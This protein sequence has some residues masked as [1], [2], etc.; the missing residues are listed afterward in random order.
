V[1]FVDANSIYGVGYGLG[2]F[3]GLHAG[4]LDNRFA[5][6]VSVCGPQPFRVD[7]RDNQY[8]GIAR[9][10]QESM[11]LPRL[12]LFDGKETRVPYDI[13]NLIASFAPK[14]VLVICPLL[15]REARAADV[16]KSVEAARA[17]FALLGA[18]EKLEH[19]KPEDYNRFGPEMQTLVVEWLK[20]Q[21][22]K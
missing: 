15:D 3:A 18:P 2:S 16:E 11:L 12:G 20:K 1:K 19:L 17:A 8:G 7:T 21:V 14:P 10:A 6:F 5:G 9:W 22:F 13:H 4:A